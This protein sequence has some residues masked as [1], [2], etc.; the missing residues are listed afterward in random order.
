MNPSKG[1]PDLPRVEHASLAPKSECFI[2]VSGDFVRT[3]GMDMANYYLADFIA[4]AGN[5]VHIV[6]HRVDP[7]LLAYAN[8]IWRRASRPWGSHIIGERFLRRLGHAVARSRPLEGAKTIVNGGNCPLPGV[9]WVHYVHAATQIHDGLRGLRKWK[10]RLSHRLALEDEA[11]ALRCAR[12]IIVNSNRT[13]NDLLQHY[14]LPESRIHTVYYGSDPTLFHPVDDTTQKAL[15]LALGLPS[16]KFLI[17]FIGALGDRRK[18]FDTLFEA[19][20]ALDA[21]FRQEVELVVVGHG[22]ELP[23]WRR[24]AAELPGGGAI[25]FLG[26]R[27]DVPNILKACDALVAPTRYEAFGLAVQEALCCGLPA[28]VSRDAGVAELFPL[29]LAGLLLDDPQNTSELTA[30]M[31]LLHARRNAFREGACQ[32]SAKLRTY[33]WE[34]MAR[35]IHALAGADG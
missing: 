31:H 30:K 18:G 33:T 1:S 29:S 21:K 12:I 34:H 32:F 4:R 9:N 26:F 20:R 19:W 25:R 6:S 8:V 14:K 5:P 22:A 17:A 10:N 11:K 3:G 27:R 2:L 16:D 35:S 23:L 24:R 28:M 13:K 7:A 15:R